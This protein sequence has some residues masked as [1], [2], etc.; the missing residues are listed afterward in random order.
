MSQPEIEP[1]FPDT[2]FREFFQKAV[3][4]NELPSWHKH[5]HERFEQ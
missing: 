5:S 3:L 2:V 1:A 4:W